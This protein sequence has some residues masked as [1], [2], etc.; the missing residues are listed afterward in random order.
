MGD[1]SLPAQI[2]LRAKSGKPF[3]IG[4]F[5]VMVGKKQSDFEFDENLEEVSR[6]HAVVEIKNGEYYIT[7]MDSTFGTMIDGKRIPAYVPRLMQNGT[8]VSFGKAGADYVFR[9]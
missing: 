4:R 5:D 1:R 7:D 9:K 6:H 2:E 8:R 3:K